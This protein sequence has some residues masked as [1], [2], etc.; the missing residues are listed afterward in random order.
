M[1]KDPGI[2]SK[3]SATVIEVKGHCS[4]GHQVGNTFELSA[5]NPS[6]MC[7][8]FYHDVFPSLCVLQFGGKFPWWEGDTAFVKCPDPINTVTVKLERSDR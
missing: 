3:I 2:G 4:A 8:F 5:H 7:G 1:A 6:Q